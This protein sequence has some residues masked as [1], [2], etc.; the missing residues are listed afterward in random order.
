MSGALSLRTL[1]RIRYPES[2]ANACSHL[3]SFGARHSLSVC[4]FRRRLVRQICPSET[5]PAVEPVPGPAADVQ[6]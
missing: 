5:R 6:R 3:N 2:L 4:Q 1:L